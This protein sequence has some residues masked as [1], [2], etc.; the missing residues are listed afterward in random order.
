MGDRPRS[1]IHE[2]L[3]KKE[4]AI[5]MPTPIYNMVIVVFWYEITSQEL[6]FPASRAISSLPAGNGA[7]LG[8]NADYYYPDFAGIYITSNGQSGQNARWVVTFTEAFVGKK[9]KAYENFGSSWYVHEIQVWGPGTWI[10]ENPGSGPA[11]PNQVIFGNPV[12]IFNDFEPDERDPNFPPPT[13]NPFEPI[14]DMQRAGMSACG[15]TNSVMVTLSEP[16]G[17]AILQV[18]VYR[19]GVPYDVSLADLLAGFLF[20]EAGIYRMVIYYS[21]MG[22]PT[23]VLTE[24]FTVL[25]EPYS[26]VQVERT[27]RGVIFPQSPVVF[28]NI[29]LSNGSIYNSTYNGQ[30]TFYFCGVFLIKWFVVPELGMA[31][32][33]VDFAV[34]TE[35]A[36]SLRGSSHVKVSAT[37]GFTIIEVSSVPYTVRLINTSDGEIVLSDA[38]QATAG[39]VI[40]KIE[41]IS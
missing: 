36:Q 16:T 34:V 22:N 11:T 15:V 8:A 25:V 38:T 23:Q 37:T 39:L 33:G 13:Y 1:P 40:V 2:N 32:D 41:E 4:S 20:N 17:L 31:T 28:D 27:Y 9:I 14:I 10:M 12:D 26:Y 29:L 30:V 35:N 5:T 6:P 18:L 7:L 3:Y 24:Y 21:F 19:D